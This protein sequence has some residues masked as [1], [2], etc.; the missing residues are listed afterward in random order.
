[1]LRSCTAKGMNIH[2]TMFHIS[3]HFKHRQLVIQLTATEIK[4]RKE[5]KE[6]ER[7]ERREAEEQGRSLL[8]FC[9]DLDIKSVRRLLLTEPPAMAINYKNNGGN[10]PLIQACNGTKET[11]AREIAQMLVEYHVKKTPACDVNIQNKHGLTA[12]HLAAKRSY[13]SVIEVL[14]KHGAKQ[15]LRAKAESSRRKN[16][17]DNGDND[18]EKEEEG[19]LPI[20]LASD[21]VCVQLLEKAEECEQAAERDAEAYKEGMK[22][23][24]ILMQLEGPIDGTEKDLNSFLEKGCWP[25]A[26]GKKDISDPYAESPIEFAINREDFNLLRK[27]LEEGGADGGAL[28]YRLC[29]LPRLPSYPLSAASREREEGRVASIEYILK[30][31]NAGD[32]INQKTGVNGYTPLMAAAVL[33][34][35]EDVPR[36]LKAGSN[37]LATGNRKE[38]ALTI[39]VRRNHLKFIEALLPPVHDPNDK[40]T[41]TKKTKSSLT[42]RQMLIDHV[43]SGNMTALMWAACSGKLDVAALLLKHN[44]DDGQG[45]TSINLTTLPYRYTALI[46]AVECKQEAMIKLLLSKGADPNLALTNGSTPLAIASRLNLSVDTLDALVK[47]K[48]NPNCRTAD[49]LTALHWAC[50]NNNHAV[51]K[52]LAISGSNPLHRDSHQRTVIDVSRTVETRLM[53]A[54][55]AK[56]YTKNMTE[57]EIAKA[58]ASPKRIARNPSKKTAD[59]QDLEGEFK[60]PDYPGGNKGNTAKETVTNIE[61]KSKDDNVKK[62]ADNSVDTGDTNA[63]V[64]SKGSR[65]DKKG[66]KSSSANAPSAARGKGN[67]GSRSSSVEKKRGENVRG[68]STGSVGSV[69][70]SGRSKSPS[71]RSSSASRK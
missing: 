5:Q 68:S 36:L 47:A 12:L 23:M 57:E 61:G 16:D 64:A 24:N 66:K 14:L 40:K 50:M 28:L 25:E 9:A 58:Y 56:H 2:H 70:S 43:D 46:H 51:A 49:G 62:G 1:M 59:G 18:D 37:I 11:Q 27:F 67:P 13:S 33:G 21:T 63:S 4:A 3:P 52:F 22:L 7:L 42:L 69:A 6:K 10:T 19:E 34:T 65:G 29:S 38:T 30:S 35:D 60:I 20:D 71:K 8:S 48:A 54:E 44:T 41:K 32:Y 15:R 53:L 45:E 17:K 55:A 39:A 26:F 31:P